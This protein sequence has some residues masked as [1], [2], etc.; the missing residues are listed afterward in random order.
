MGYS[1]VKVVRNV[2]DDAHMSI[3]NLIQLRKLVPT[4]T[5]F[6]KQGIYYTIS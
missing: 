2:G 4:M 3:E 5:V 1:F 6:M